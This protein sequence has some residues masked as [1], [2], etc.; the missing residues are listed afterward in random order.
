MFQKA[1]C[2]HK[3]NWGKGNILL[4]IKDIAEIAGVSPT[5]VSNVIHGN[6]KKV[7]KDTIEKINRVIKENNFVPNSVNGKYVSENGTKIIGV[8]MNS[9]KDGNKE[10]LTDPFAGEIIGS[11]ESEVFKLGYYM[12]FHMSED[13]EE[14][15]ELACKWRVD[16]LITIGL[17]P[18]ENI[19]IKD[20]ITVPM[21]SVDTY[22]SGKDRVANV[23]LDD[24]SGGYQMTK[25]LISMGHRDIMFVVDST[26]GFNVD[27]IEGFKQALKEEKIDSTDK[28]FL[29]NKDSNERLK[30]YDNEMKKILSN[31]A[32]F[33]SSDF[34]AFEAIRYF[35]DLGLRVPEDISVA[36]FDDNYLAKMSRPRITTVC[37]DIRKKGSFAVNMLDTLIKGETLRFDN[38]RLPVQLIKRESVK[39]I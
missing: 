7:S 15:I 17:P 1:L 35:K 24:Y 23:G 34:Y 5:T 37:Q 30:M 18:K 38:L 16:G 25:Y 3:K 28:V 4:R 11:I 27:R 26:L 31:T 8:I 14:S 9:T 6:T 39:E 29:I 33:F 21:V 2:L 10:M 12:L 13:I 36:G 22:Y 32:L 20:K 19:I